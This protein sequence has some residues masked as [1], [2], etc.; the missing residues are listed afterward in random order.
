MKANKYAF[1]FFSFLLFQVN[2][3]AIKSDNDLRHDKEI[4]Q[5]IAKSLESNV[6]G[7]FKDI[8][9]NELKET[10]GF[11]GTNIR[12]SNMQIEEVEN[13]SVGVMQ[14]ND[15]QTLREMQGESVTYQCDK[16]NCEVGHTFSSLSKVKRQEE[17]E[18]Q[19]FEKDENGMPIN[20]LG[21][22]DKANVFAKNNNEFDFLSGT[23]SNCKANEETITT[24]TEDT[25][26]QY[27]DLKTHSCFPKQVVEIDP[28][29][30]YTCNKIREEK[31]KTCREEI[32][33]I[34]CKDS[35]ECDLGGIER[36]SVDSDMK[37][38]FNNGVLTIGT[39]ADNYWGGHCA[40]YDRTTTFK[41]T[42]KDKIKD[43]FLFKVGFDDYMQIILNGHLIYIGPDGGNKLEVTTVGSR[44]W[45]HQVVDN[46]SGHHACERGV[47][48]TREP[49]ID[50]R[51]YLKEGENILKT[52]VIVA[53]AGEGWMQIRAKQNCCSK[54]E[55]KRE[56]KCDLS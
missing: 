13:L 32:T 4:G 43:F 52:R 34:T 9:S 21:Y 36:G 5:E 41:I 45:K 37:F 17:L 28:E 20:N 39:I 23:T 25:C 7:S 22:L 3:F 47:S 46:G 24:S 1:T 27:Y 6:A 49:N 18:K 12:G 8:N 48:W 31:I 55:I 10:I 51:P 42:N 29:Y 35:H 56:E 40:I 54:W 19:G 53:G 14:H 44:F 11:E 30:K 50:L 38:E 15:D 2:A 26:D 16:N 33:S